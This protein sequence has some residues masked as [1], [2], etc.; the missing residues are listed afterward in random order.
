M[1]NFIY[2]YYIL[3]KPVYLNYKTNN[4]WILKSRLKINNK[5]HYQDY[6]EGEE[7]EELEFIEY[8]KNKLDILEGNGIIK[9]YEIK[10]LI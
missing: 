6:F 7:E 9:K 3:D 4:T 1:K 8:V 5:Y 2:V 10:K